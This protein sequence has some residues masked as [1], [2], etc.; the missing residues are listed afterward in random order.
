LLGAATGVSNGN[1]DRACT[2]RGDEC[3]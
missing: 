3:Q 2:S 1:L